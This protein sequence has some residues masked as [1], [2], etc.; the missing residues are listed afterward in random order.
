MT[1]DERDQVVLHLQLPASL[2]RR[3]NEAAAV[4]SVSV[5][6]VAI[7]VIQGA[8]PYSSVNQANTEGEATRGYRWKNVFLPEG[9]LLYFNYLGTQ[10]LAAIVDAKFTHDGKAMSPSEFVNRISGATRNAWRDIWIKRPNDSRW[11][12][13]LDLRREVSKAELSDS[14]HTAM[15]AA[16]ATANTMIPAIGAA[17]ATVGVSGLAGR[18]RRFGTLPISAKMGPRYLAACRT[19]PRIVRTLVVSEDDFDQISDAKGMFNRIVREDQ[20]DWQDVQRV[21][22]MPDHKACKLAALWL[23]ELRLLAKGGNAVDNHCT[24]PIARIVAKALA[25]A[26]RELGQRCYLDNDK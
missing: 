21:L 6:Q 19:I 23:T 12:S 8:F 16:L 26:E 7:D 13:A 11:A 15:S 25:S 1:E 22:G 17:V 24:T 14:S 10:H 3:L 4:R 9:T 2:A 5:E 18:R 20:H